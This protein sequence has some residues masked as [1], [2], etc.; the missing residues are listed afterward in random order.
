MSAMGH[1]AKCI[2]SDC[3]RDWVHGRGAA[4]E[5]HRILAVLRQTDWNGARDANDDPFEGDYNELARLIADFIERPESTSEI[6]SKERLSSNEV[7]NG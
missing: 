5:R 7:S 6:E 3:Y 2:C 4:E 1:S